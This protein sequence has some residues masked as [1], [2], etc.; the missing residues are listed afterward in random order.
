MRPTSPHRFPSDNI[1]IVLE[2]LVG[3]DG[4]VLDG[5]HCAA[6]RIQ[7][8]ATGTRTGLH[9]AQ[10]DREGRGMASTALV[11][12]RRRHHEG[13]RPCATSSVDAMLAQTRGAGATDLC[14]DS[15]VE[16]SGGVLQSVNQL[17][18]GPFVSHSVDSAR[19]P[20]V[21]SVAQHRTRRHRRGVHAEVC[22]GGLEVGLPWQRT[23]THDPVRG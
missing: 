9:P 15:R 2:Y 17:C 4:D 13:L 6:I 14:M 5:V 20:F 11:R 12:A 1:Q 10:V 3:G 22:G 16:E 7:S 8:T 19:R 21:T 23:H 18:R